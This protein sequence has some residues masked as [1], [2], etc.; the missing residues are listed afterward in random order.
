MVGALSSEA[1]PKIVRLASNSG[2]RPNRSP[3]G[4]ADSA[5]VGLC[6]DFSGDSGAWRLTLRFH[7]PKVFYM[8]AQNKKICYYHLSPRY[9]VTTLSVVSCLGSR[10]DG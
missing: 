10:D 6:F 8:A 4:P 7:A 2:R 5:A 1:I 3:I 9:A